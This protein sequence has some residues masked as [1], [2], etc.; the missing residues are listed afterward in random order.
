MA[1]PLPGRTSDRHTV[2]LISRAARSPSQPAPARTHIVLALA[3][4]CCWLRWLSASSPDARRDSTRV[5]VDPA[6][7]SDLEALLRRFYGQVLVD[8]IFA[9][10]FTEIRA[11][12]VAPS[13]DVR[14]WETVL[15]RA[16]LYG[17]RPHSAY[18]NRWRPTVTFP[19]NGVP[20]GAGY[21]SASAVNR[22]P[23]SSI[24]SRLCRSGGTRA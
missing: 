23:Q 16:G 13:D 7:R 22:L 19:S 20:T 21:W 5:W 11:N 8:N 18:W 2:S 10:P 14:F 24:A 12:G 9:E 6:S 1:Q 15:F 17:Q 4:V 3:K